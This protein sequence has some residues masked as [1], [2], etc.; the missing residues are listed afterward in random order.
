MDSD[1]LV[2]EEKFITAEKTNA[3]VERVY[4][5]LKKYGIEERAEA[6]WIVSITANV[7]RDDLSSD[8]YIR[9]I[10]I[11]KINKIVAERITGRPLW[12]CIGDTEFY[13][14]K[15][16]VDERVL[17][18]RPETELLAEEV[19]KISKVNTK[20]LDL[21]TGSGAIAISVK[22]E[23]NAEVYAS[24]I[25]QDALNLAS[26]NAKLNDAQISFI[27]SDLFNSIDG[28]FDVIVSNPPYIKNEDIPSLQK[29]V[30]D[31]EPILA[32]DGGI[33]GLDFYREIAKNAKK[34]LKKG[35]TLLL[36]VGFNQANDVKLMLRDFEKVEVI[37][38]FENIDRIVKA[39]Y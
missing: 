33:D 32:L 38:D 20:V 19:I 2:P 30:K 39:V 14:Y 16:K 7:K 15:I 35:G 31:F 3:L 22:K 28:E 21:C 9:P 25:S 34:H 18:P 10:I 1:E 4:N 29:E 6:E 26:E 24:D 23:T 13:G 5:E 8:K 17:I 11:E 12:Y 37:K 27:Q 36:E